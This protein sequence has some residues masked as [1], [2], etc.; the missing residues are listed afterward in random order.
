M[1]HFE[2]FSENQHQTTLVTEFAAILRATVATYN[3]T[4]ICLN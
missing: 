1:Y 3:L 4:S 2:H